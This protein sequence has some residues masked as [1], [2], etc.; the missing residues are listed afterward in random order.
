M[1]PLL[2]FLTQQNNDAQEDG[3]QGAGAE[4]SGEQQGFSTAGLHVALVVASAHSD[5][6][7]ARA[8]LNRVI[9]V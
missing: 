8:A 3:D 5:G 4:A 9:I 7:R 1:I 6:Q 2:S